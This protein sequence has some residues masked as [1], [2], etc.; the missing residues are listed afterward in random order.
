MPE[1]Q[2]LSALSSV[3]QN[4]WIKQRVTNVIKS[5]HN[6]ADVIAEPVQNAV[7]EVLS[8][9]GITG[10]GDVT[11]V[12]DADQNRIS[13]IDNGRGISSEDVAK[14]LAPDMGTKRK[15]FL[16]GWVRGHKG[17]GMTFLV[18]GFDFFELESRTLDGEHYRVRMEGG[19]TWVADESLDI[20]PPVGYLE[21]LSGGGTLQ[22]HGTRVT[23]GLGPKT[24]PR[25][26]KR[27]FPTAEFATIA[28][29]NQTAIGI[30]E[31]PSVLKKR[32]LTARLE[33][34][35]DAKTE[36]ISLVAQYRYPHMQLDKTIRALDLDEWFR[37]NR[38]T[39]PTVRDRSAYHACHSTLGPEAL[40]KLIADR[41]GHSLT[42]VQEVHSYI[43]KHKVHVYAMFSHS[44]SYRDL[45][46]EAWKVPKNRVLHAPRLRVATDGMISSWSREV[47]LT[48]RGFNVDR[49]WLTYQLQ[50]VEPDMGRKD[51]PPDLHDFLQIS[52]ERVAN[53]IARLSKPF[54]RPGPRRTPASTEG[55][56]EPAI[57]AYERRKSPL[58]PSLIPG[59]DEISLRT[60]PQS[61]QDVIAL[62]SEL[63]GLGV[64]R[65]FKPVFYSG[66]DYYDSYFEY[67][68]GE[69]H[70][71]VREKIP[72]LSAVDARD[73][74]GV[75][76]FK[77]QGDWILD[78]L[79]SGVKRWEDMKFLVCWSIGKD[80][81]QKA[82]DEVVFR[83]AEDS[84]D[85][86]FHGVTH[87][88]TL[89]SAGSR[90]I[91]VISLSDVL[92][93]LASSD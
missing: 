31:P 63:V 22:A 8:A 72:G 39:E 60:A 92:D 5:Y 50:G 44:A 54:L 33:Y 38:S 70:Q 37:K 81:S 82:G 77:F 73:S 90:S 1:I 48:H 68:P 30:V 16:Q 2:P 40:K 34:I 91:F 74:S 14:Y 87:L 71:V 35:S 67:A 42:T 10:T 19:R 24:E 21:H 51:F 20:T 47:T 57:K 6:A 65:H 56:I 52:E 89:Q 62:F 55:Y 59:F 9:D 17:V 18:Y 15:A 80:V 86:Q 69:V 29:Q 7:D 88:A 32:D 13:V 78:D 76:E 83:A 85:R 25:E 23:I 84:A 64:L 41:T 4:G 43:D 26:L 66:F 49:T 28:L 79:V 53:E 3:V 27:A 93:T 11:V 75:A 61:E 58:V 46:A 12:L 36:K 45:L